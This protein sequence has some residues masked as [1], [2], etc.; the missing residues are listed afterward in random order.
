MIEIFRCPGG[1]TVTGHAGY[2]P[3]GR[4][5]VCAGVSALL[6]T[7]IASLEELTQDKITYTLQPGLAQVRYEELSEAGALLV[8]SF[9]I[10]VRLMA[11]AYPQYVR[12]VQARKTEKAAEK[13]S[14]SFKNSEVIT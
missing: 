12:V 3:P 1:L 2:A 6:Q 4:D 7:L 8:G 14:E 10:G 5:I 13:T 11:E 9:F